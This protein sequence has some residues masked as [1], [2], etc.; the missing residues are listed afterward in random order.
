MSAL[1]QFLDLRNPLAVAIGYQRG[2]EPG[3][4]S[5]FLAQK[6][7]QLRRVAVAPG[8]EQLVRFAFRLLHLFEREVEEFDLIRRR[9]VIQQAEL[10]LHGFEPGDFLVIALSALLKL[11]LDA[12]VRVEPEFHELQL[13][14]GHRGH[15]RLEAI[16]GFGRKAERVGLPRHF[17]ETDLA[18]GFAQRALVSVDAVLPASR[19]VPAWG[20]GRPGRS[21]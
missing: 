21:P 17:L 19:P 18:D 20:R 15:P 13:L 6:V 16:H 12:G 8:C 11:F 5:V 7:C 4:G 2:I 9:Q 1:Q 10:L 3:R 14:E